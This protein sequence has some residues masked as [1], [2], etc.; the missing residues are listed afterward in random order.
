MAVQTHTT[1]PVP[2][3]VQFNPE[4]APV[5]PAEAKTGL[6]TLGYSEDGLTISERP[7]RSDVHSDRNGGLNGEP[8]DDQFFGVEV[9]IRGKLTEWDR[10]VMKRIRSFLPNSAGS[11]GEVKDIGC[12][13]LS[14]NQFFRLLLYGEKDKKA[15][16]AGGTVGDYTTPMNFRRVRPNDVNELT[17]GSK[18]TEVQIHFRAYMFTDA[19]DADK[20]KIWNRNILA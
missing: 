15:I 13:T 5:P 10:N 7:L 4:D 2:L 1:G 20:R 11:D 6:L 14:E 16:D 9:M 18:V 8:V 19:A 12:L 3:V 17:I